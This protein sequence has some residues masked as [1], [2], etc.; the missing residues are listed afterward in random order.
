MLSLEKSPNFIND[1]KRFEARIN[2]VADKEAQI[3]LK[4]ILLSLKNEVKLFDIQHNDTTFN[5]R[6]PSIALDTR[7]KI[8][9]IR[10]KLSQRLLEWGV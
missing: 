6:V 3:E 5:N 4:K 9:E 2:Q 8:K 7:N 1:V 10:E